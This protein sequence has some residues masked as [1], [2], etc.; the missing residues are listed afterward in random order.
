MRSYIAWINGIQRMI[1]HFGMA[2]TKGRG[3]VQ[4][5]VASTIPFEFVHS[6]DYIELI[7]D[8]Q[9]I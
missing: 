1:A 4:T 3:W 9:L 6:R 8:A 5:H 7:N 2:P